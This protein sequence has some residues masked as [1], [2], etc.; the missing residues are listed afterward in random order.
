[1]VFAAFTER[2][3][4]GSSTRWLDRH[5]QTVVG[6]LVRSSC[7]R[8]APHTHPHPQWI[9]NV[10]CLRGKPRRLRGHLGEPMSL[11]VDMVTGSAP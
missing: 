9:G 1:V 4:G 11:V 7:A 2:Y 6:R 10:W 8:C 3:Q 5:I